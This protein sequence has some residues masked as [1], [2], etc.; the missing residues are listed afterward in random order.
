MRE[1]GLRA[2]PR[3]RGLPRDAG[4][5]AAASDNLPDRAFEASAPDQKWVADFTDIW[6]A[7]GWLYVAAVVDLFSPRVVVHRTGSSPT[8]GFPVAWTPG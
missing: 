3:R 5:R 2:R 8:K 6:A 4:V 1:L 7:E